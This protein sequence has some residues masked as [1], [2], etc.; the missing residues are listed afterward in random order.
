MSC[1][2]PSPEAV[3]PDSQESRWVRSAG[4]PG[5][6]VAPAAAACCVPAA[7]HDPPPCLAAAQRP[8]SACPPAMPLRCCRP[9]WIRSVHP[10]DRHEA[11]LGA[12]AQ[13]H[14]A[15]GPSTP[16]STT[17]ALHVLLKHRISWQWPRLPPRRA[18]SATASRSSTRRCLPSCSPQTP[19]RRA[20][21]QAAA[22][23]YK[24]SFA[25]SWPCLLVLTPLPDPAPAAS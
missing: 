16:V 5:S 18:T 12:P 1:G 6:A 15:G 23:G 25:S 7:L 8:P 13:D 21:R 10:R 9:P 19:T 4:T 3:C 20:G 11:V 17:R 22:S 24:G 2:A 14:A